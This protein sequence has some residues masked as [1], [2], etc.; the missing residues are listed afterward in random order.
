MREILECAVLAVPGL[1]PGLPQWAVAGVAADADT[2]LGAAARQGG[3][4]RL[5]WLAC[6]AA[7]QADPAGAI[8]ALALRLRRYDAC[9]LPIDP[10]T[11]PWARLALARA[12]PLLR[13]PLLALVREMRAPAVADL[14]DLGAADFL[15]APLDVEELRARLVRVLSRGTALQAPAD[16]AQAAEAAGP[17]SRRLAQAV[18]LGAR[19][20][21]E[22][23]IPAAGRWAETGAEAGG[24][25]VSG[26]S[27]PATVREP[28]R[29]Y[30]YGPAHGAALGAEY[31]TAHG[32][33]AGPAGHPA[34]A[35][36][37]GRPCAPARPRQAPAAPRRMA[38][39]AC[40]PEDPDADAE[41]FRLAKARVVAGF[42]TAYLHRALERHGGNVARAA[43]ASC[44]HR[45]AFWALM[46]KHR[47]DAAPYRQHAGDDGY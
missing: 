40:T 21:A 9:L 14:F 38:A 6:D 34:A 43:R 1:A 19:R 8:A 3:R 42:E 28:A 31:G 4:L 10:A 23:A 29:A 22:T 5:H 2:A 30:A 17:G 47:I 41:P 39:P 32:R 15:C 46:R 11:L 20:S 44:K 12:R 25:S 33:A 36:G 16:P 37:A 18:I 7:A 27:M 13:T 26:A 24:A 35:P 45:R